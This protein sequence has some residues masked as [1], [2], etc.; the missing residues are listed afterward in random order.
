[1]KYLMYRV[2][3]EYI[4]I[5]FP[6]KLTHRHVHRRMETLMELDR[7]ILV[8]GGEVSV[9]VL[10]AHGSSETCNVMANDI[11]RQR[12]NVLDYSGGLD[13]PMNGTTEKLVL[14]AAANLIDEI[15]SHEFIVFHL[16]QLQVAAS[17]RLVR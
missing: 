16:P 3:D 6:S 8:S 11:D 4:P 12:I 9:A 7:A 1:M 14:V 15:L 5:I 2:G 10:G 17:K 13:T